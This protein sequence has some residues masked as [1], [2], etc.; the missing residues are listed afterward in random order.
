MQRKWN[1]VCEF[2]I[3]KKRGFFGTESAKWRFHDCTTHDNLRKSTMWRRRSRRKG[4][5]ERKKRKRKRR[6][7][8]RGKKGERESGNTDQTLP[9]CKNRNTVTLT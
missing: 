9:A 8:K 5:E 2:E 6:E 1:I 7:K 3:K 4:E